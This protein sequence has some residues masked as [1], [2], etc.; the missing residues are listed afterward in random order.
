MLDLADACGQSLRSLQRRFNEAFGISPEEF[1]IKT[2]VS[3]AMKLLQLRDQLNR[4]SNRQPVR[5]CGCEKL[6]RSI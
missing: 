2:R 6:V 4:R 3:E 5:I 1:L